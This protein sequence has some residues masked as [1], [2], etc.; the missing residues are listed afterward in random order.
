VVVIA[1]SSGSSG[2]VE[3][4]A[5]VVELGGASE[6]GGADDDRFDVGGSTSTNVIFDAIAYI[7]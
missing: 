1:E 3:R 5:R 2:E 6:P 7:A 4:L